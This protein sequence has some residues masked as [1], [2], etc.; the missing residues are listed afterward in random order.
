[1]GGISYEARSELDA[2]GVI[3]SKQRWFLASWSYSHGGKGM[4]GDGWDGK[5]HQ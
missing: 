1:M 4:E 2:R 5:S 3:G